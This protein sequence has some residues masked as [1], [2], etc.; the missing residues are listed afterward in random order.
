MDGMVAAIRS[1]SDPPVV[2]VPAPIVNVPAPVVNV[3]APIVYT[4]SFV[5]AVEDLRK[6][7]AA[8][9]TKRLERDAEGRIVALIET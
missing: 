8:P 5:E 3:E 6:L 9:R 2:N 7:I 4:D 1:L